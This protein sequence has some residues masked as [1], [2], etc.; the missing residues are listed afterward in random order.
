MKKNIIM[1]LMVG[2]LLSIIGYFFLCRLQETDY[3]VNYYGKVDFDFIIPSPWFNQISEIENKPF[4]ADI[5]PY[6][7]TDREIC[8]KHNNSEIYIYLIE[9]NANLGITP[10]SEK[11]IID[12]TALRQ[13]GIVIDESVKN[14]LN[15]SVGDVLSIHIGSKVFE[16]EVN[17]VVQSNR[18]A[19]KLSTAIYLS[20]EIKLAYEQNVRHAVYSAAFVK[21][22]DIV[23]AEH[24]FNEDYRAMGKAG[25]R[26][27][28]NDDDTYDFARNSIMEIP[29]GKE[30]TNIA[31][32]KANAISNTD[33]AQK[34][35][36]RI[37]IYACLFV[38]VVNIIVW[39]AK[40]FAQLKTIRE[41][42]IRKKGEDVKKIVDEFKFGE[43]VTFIIFVLS[44]VL[45]KN[46][47][48]N[49]QL[50]ALAIFELL[51]LIVVISLTNKIFN[52]N[53]NTANREINKEKE[54]CN[55]NS[56]N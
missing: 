13:N 22:S 56:E 11:F 47:A 25:D 19:S 55:E 33:T 24:Y 51:S 40:I 36:I 50:V 42:R 14:L 27:W 41:N 37:L 7:L 39:I 23:E 16:V 26:S 35:N 49:I 34:A 8:S 53:K 4:V 17:G 43:I 45:L 1:G 15:V 38:F 18:F 20:N 52:R 12:G 54:N 29:V 10:F 30:V 5:T 21:A 44:F 46:I 2:F 48:T 3:D 32:I 6:Y 9:E 31:Q 28:Y